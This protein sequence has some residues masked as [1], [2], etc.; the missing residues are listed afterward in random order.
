M[1]GHGQ[2]CG[3]GLNDRTIHGTVHWNQ[4]GHVEY[5]NS[6]SLPSGSKFADEYHVFSII[7]TENSIKW[8]VD[9]V[10][11]SQISITPAELAAFHENFFLIFNVAVGGNWP[12]SPDGSTIFPQSMYVDYVRV[13][14]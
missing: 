4:G 2:V 14:Q 10:Q 5:G 7:W 9:D 13:F 12:G 11:Y 1:H 6:Y 3:T 8:L